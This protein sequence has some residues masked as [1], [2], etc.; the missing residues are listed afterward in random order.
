MSYLARVYLACIYS[1]QFERA[2]LNKSSMA[3]GPE[4]W[5]VVGKGG[6]PRKNQEGNKKHKAKINQADLPKLDIKGNPASAAFV[7]LR[8]ELK[9]R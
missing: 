8:H 2:D 4:K 1:S 3:S 5:E 9:Y 7:H 6:K